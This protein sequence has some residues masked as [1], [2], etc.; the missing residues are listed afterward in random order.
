MATGLKSRVIYRTHADGDWAGTYKLLM[1]AKTIP[2]PVGERSMVDVS[3]LEDEMEVQE[4]GRRAAASLS[5]TGAMEKDYLDAMNELSDANVD[6]IILYGT[7]GLGSIAKYGFQAKGGIDVTPDEAS[8]D[9]LT[10]T[11]TIPVSSVPKLITDEYEVAVVYEED[12]TTVKEFT[13]SKK[14]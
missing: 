7:D 5:L 14:A 10:M 4:P 2:S 13:V 9:H 1:R 6:I 8:D 3:T 12:G 11:A